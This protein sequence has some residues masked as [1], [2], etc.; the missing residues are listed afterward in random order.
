LAKKKNSKKVNRVVFILTSS[1]LGLVVIFG[2]P[3]YMFLNYHLVSKNTW[4]STQQKLDEQDKTIKEQTAKIAYQEKMI[5]DQ[6]AKVGSANSSANNV[7][8]TGN[9]NPKNQP[10]QKTVE[11]KPAIAPI[12]DEK[13]DISTTK[14]GLQEAYQEMGLSAN[15]SHNGQV[16]DLAKQLMNYRNQHPQST[17]MVADAL[18]DLGIPENAAPSLITIRRAIELIESK[19]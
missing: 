17:Y 18:R 6:A 10:A 3:I 8:L 19:R 7:V 12:Q 5:K 9:T 14:Y 2:T 11:I 16:K 4:I 1:V 15:N 13:K